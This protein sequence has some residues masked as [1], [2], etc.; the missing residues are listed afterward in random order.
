MRIV[1]PIVLTLCVAGFFASIGLSNETPTIPFQGEIK[2]DEANVRAD[3]T[4]TSEVLCGLTRGEPVEV[5]GEAFEWYKIKLPK[6]APSFIKKTL[7]APIDDKTI[8]VLKNNVNIRVGPSELTAIV[9]RTNKDETL[10]VLASQ[11][12]W[13]K[14]TPSQHSVGWINKKFVLGF[15]TGI[16]PQ[17]KEAPAEAELNTVKQKPS[18]NTGTPAE[19]VAEG[20]VEPYGKVL[21]RLA[22]HKLII[23]NAS[24]FLLRGSLKSLNALNY[25][26]VRITGKVI[27]TKVKEKY[28]V[29]EIEKVELLN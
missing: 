14:I 8:K 28:P 26:K 11:G 15:R 25:H 23:N 9:G 22:T 10:S 5:I 13:F 2:S 12:E 21:N 18:E 19:V 24:T 7:V 4:I 3:S 27:Q 17:K 6:K 20:I 16:V 29:L 1:Q